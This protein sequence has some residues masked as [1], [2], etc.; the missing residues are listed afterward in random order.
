MV[1]MII[2]HTRADLS[3]PQSILT[4]YSMHFKNKRKIKTLT[5]SS[6]PSGFYIKGQVFQ[7]LSVWFSS[8]LPSSNGRNWALKSRR[9]AR[10]LIFLLT[11]HN[12][13]SFKRHTSHHPSSLLPSPQI[14]MPPSQEIMRQ[15]L[16]FFL[17]SICYKCRE[18]SVTGCGSVASLGHL[19]DTSDNS[20]HFTSKNKSTGSLYE[21]AIK[22]LNG[23]SGI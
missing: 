14:S 6:T 15:T 21:V 8:T 17:V 5:L 4:V 20:L 7:K 16:Q 9:P 2:L 3:N 19:W 11:G 1:M 12:A 10:S 22:L 13:S 18:S 23:K